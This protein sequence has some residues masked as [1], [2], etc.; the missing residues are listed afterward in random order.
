MAISSGSR[1]DIGFRPIERS[2][3]D[4]SLPTGAM[5]EFISDATEDAAATNAFVAALLSHIIDKSGICLWVSSSRA[6]FPAAMQAFGITSHRL[7]FINVK[8]E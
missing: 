3:P 6:L 4:N 5:H 7:I 1:L 8:K 2:F